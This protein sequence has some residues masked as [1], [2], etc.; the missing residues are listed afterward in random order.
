MIFYIE[1]IGGS[2]TK[3]LQGKISSASGKY[4][5]KLVIEIPPDLQQPAPGL[6]GALTDL[7]TYAVQQEGQEQP[8]LDERLQE[9]EAHVRREA[10]VRR[11]LRPG[12]EA[13]RLGHVDGEVQVVTR[14]QS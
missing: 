6:Y 11:E 10:D 1:Q 5:Q 2:V 9:E 13:E 7:K 14:R 3:A 4:K 12:A 8:D